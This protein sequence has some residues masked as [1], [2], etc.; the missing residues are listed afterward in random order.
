MVSA[1]LPRQERFNEKLS[2]ITGNGVS[3]MH[4]FIQSF[5]R[6]EAGVTA[7]EYGMIA[8]LIAVA[9]LG[10]LSTLGQDLNR[11]FGIIQAGLAKPLN[12]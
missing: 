2:V 9:I 4:N 1:S 6:D 3:P 7:M 5:I 12:S 10:V 8:A 11:T